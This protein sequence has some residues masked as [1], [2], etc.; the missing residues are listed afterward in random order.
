M[1]NIFLIDSDILSKFGRTNNLHILEAVP[2]QILITR[3]IYS[4][5]VDG[6]NFG[7]PGAVAALSW[8]DSNANNPNIAVSRVYLTKSERN[9]LYNT[10]GD[11]QHLA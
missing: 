5:I 2:G 10:N 4:E 11:S 1:S 8:L 7:A 3:E 9:A 6:A